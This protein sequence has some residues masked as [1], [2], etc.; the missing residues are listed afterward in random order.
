MQLLLYS[1]LLYSTILYSTILYATILYSALLYS[2]LGLVFPVWSEIVYYSLSEPCSD[3]RPPN[4]P[5]L[6]PLWSLLDSIWGV[7]KGT[8]GVLDYSQYPRLD[9]GDQ[10]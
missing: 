7:L 9:E 1:T 6:R 10:T 4:V 5:L 2:S 3:P 8:W